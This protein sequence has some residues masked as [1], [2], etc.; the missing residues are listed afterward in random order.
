[1]PS[2]VPLLTKRWSAFKFIERDQLNIANKFVHQTRQTFSLNWQVNLFKVAILSE[3]KRE[4]T[5][6]NEEAMQK[7]GG[8]LL[9]MQKATA[10]LS[11]Q[12]EH[13]WKF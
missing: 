1:M 13:A 9:I 10:P 6:D 2:L 8:Q 12:L 11:C 4:E 3:L 5:E 7:N